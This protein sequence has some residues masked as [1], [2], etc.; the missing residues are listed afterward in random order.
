MDQV[1]LDI[2]CSASK[3]TATALATARERHGATL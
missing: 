1:G 2:V 3:S